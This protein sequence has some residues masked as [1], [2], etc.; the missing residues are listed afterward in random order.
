MNIN[1]AARLA[2]YEEQEKKNIT[3]RPVG[4]CILA[5][6]RVSTKK[7]VEEGHSV[8]GQR[9]IIDNHITRTNTLS[10]L[11]VL[12]FTDEAKSGK[13]IVNRDNF[14]KLC[15]MMRKGD[16]IITWN[17]SRLGRN[18]KDMVNFVSTLKEKGIGLVLTDINFD[19]TGPLG[20][21]ML[22]LLIA[23][24]DFERKQVSERTKVIMQQRQE[25]GFVVTRPPFG[26]QV[27]KETKKLEPNEEEQKVINL[28]A[29]WIYENPQVKDAEITRLLQERFDRGEIS[30]RKAKKI[31]QT[32]VGNIIKRN[33]LREAISKHTPT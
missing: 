14:T 9:R 25:E 31:H 16:T 19:T 23:V 21:L 4:P 33:N 24:A 5:Y 20:D 8:D 7:Q 13:N 3:S 1:I 27:N 6:I 32:T 17:L 11:P 15:D 28:I 2:K 22:T 26:S 12:Y 29:G 18:T 30:M 10:G